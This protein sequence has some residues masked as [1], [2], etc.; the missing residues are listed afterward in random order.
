MI[1]L[2]KQKKKLSEELPTV[3]LWNRGIMLFSILKTIYVLLTFKPTMEYA[4]FNK[5]NGIEC[6]KA[7]DMIHS[8]LMKIVLFN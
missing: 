4:K 2:K 6:A 3:L 5:Y 7:D 1:L 8:T